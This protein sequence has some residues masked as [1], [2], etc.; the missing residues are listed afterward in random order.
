MITIMIIFIIKSIYTV[1]H[2]VKRSVLKKW[3][4]ST[5]DEFMY[6]NFCTIVF[7]SSENNHSINTGYHY[8]YNTDND[9]VV[10]D[11]DQHSACDFKR[12]FETLICYISYIKYRNHTEAIA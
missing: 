5:A 11:F 1:S 3:N 4:I 8:H 9:C 12:Y 10:P 6:T 2:S 7:C